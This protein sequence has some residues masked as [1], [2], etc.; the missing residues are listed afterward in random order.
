VRLP[1]GDHLRISVSGISEF[2]IGYSYFSER[3]EN[4]LKRMGIWVLVLG[5]SFAL[6]LGCAAVK[7]KDVYSSYE[8]RLQELKN[9][10]GAEKAPYETAKAEGYLEMLQDEIDENDP[11]GSKL[12][13]DKVDEYLKQGMM[14]V[15]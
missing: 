1:V 5:F 3:G 2:E 11:V 9:M 4:M 6:F 13:S 14:K 10:G 12:F 15:Q 7:Y 8:V